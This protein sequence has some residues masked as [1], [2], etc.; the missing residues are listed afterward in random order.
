MAKKTHTVQLR[1]VT[2]KRLKLLAKRTGATQQVI[3]DQ[4]IRAASEGLIVIRKGA[5]VTV[6][7]N[8]KASVE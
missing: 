8:G 5:D 7:V 2:H 1:D 6:E 4:L 3:V